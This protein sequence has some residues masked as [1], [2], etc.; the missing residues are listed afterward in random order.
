MRGG[1]VPMTHQQSFNSHVP[2]HFPG[3]QRQYSQLGNS[4]GQ[5]SMPMEHGISQQQH[6]AAAQV[7]V[8]G[9]RDTSK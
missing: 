6:Q 1:G 8:N 3:Q 5:Q 7:N 4:F 2:Q 9:D